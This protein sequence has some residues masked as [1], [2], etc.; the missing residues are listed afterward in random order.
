MSALPWRPTP[1]LSQSPAGAN[2]WRFIF[3]AQVP[4]NNRF[5]RRSLGRIIAHGGEQSR[6]LSP[7]ES[8]LFPTQ[9]DFSPT[10]S[11]GGLLRVGVAP[12]EIDPPSTPLQSF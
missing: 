5:C 3:T 9:A 10:G 2:R 6:Q 4:E 8:E 11:T 7:T 1:G 12:Q